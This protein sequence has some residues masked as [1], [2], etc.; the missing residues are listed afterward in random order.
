MFCPNCGQERV[1]PDTRFCSRCGFLLTGAAE[2]VQ[3]GGLL[4]VITAGPKGPSPRSRGIKQGLFIFL[5]TFLV[6]PIVAIISKGLSLSPVG[7]A[8]TA[9]ILSIGGILRM[10]YA[11][12]FEDSA[13]SSP[14]AS[15]TGSSGLIGMPMGQQSLPPSQA[16]PVSDY[17]R[18][19]AGDWRDT[20]DLAPRSVTE[21]TTKLL[22]KD[23]PQDIR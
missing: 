19:A 1:S 22:E 15:V 17:R 20:S 21:G 5:L 10:V 3:H 23:D 14:D 12:M 6:V 2:L 18:P 13:A 7:V 9:I 8:I 4:P 11:L 16:V